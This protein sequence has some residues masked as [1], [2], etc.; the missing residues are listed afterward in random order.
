MVLTLDFQGSKRALA[1]LEGH[2]DPKA[3]QPWSQFFAA[4]MGGMFS[5]SANRLKPS[6]LPYL[7]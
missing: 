2:D 1:R 7:S 3:L 6:K 4:G 5:Q